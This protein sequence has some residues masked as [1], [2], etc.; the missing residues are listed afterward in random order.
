M[1]NKKTLISIAFIIIVI[2]LAIIIFI[3]KNPRSDSFTLTRNF[4]A[5]E[6]EEEYSEYENEFN[7][8][9]DTKK[10]YID[11]VTKQGI[12]DITLIDPNNE[13][14]T[15]SISGETQKEID[16]NKQYGTWKYIINIYRDT[17]GSV[18][19]SDSVINHENL[20][21]TNEFYK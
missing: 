17:D 15:M 13:K 12:I 3:P 4:Y 19:I 2:I 10:I 8:N 6:Y 11:G 1:R 16:V 21:R 14:H 7:V 5:D 18:T 9:Q 20:A